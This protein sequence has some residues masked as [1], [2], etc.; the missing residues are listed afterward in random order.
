MTSLK[1]IFMQR[2]QL[3]SEISENGENLSMGER[4]LI[5]IARSILKPTRIV[6]VDEA[7]ANI[8]V[9]TESIIY[10]AMN[11][12]FKNSTVITVAHRLNTVINSD[13]ILVL[14]GGLLKEY[15]N[16]QV[17]LKNPNSFFASLYNESQKE[18]K[19]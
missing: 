7:T 4:Q 15:D 11:E 19:M 9:K 13:R 18:S 10:K 1:E 5:S 17:L 6:L 16:P 2:K 3:N 14:E 12:A 8:D